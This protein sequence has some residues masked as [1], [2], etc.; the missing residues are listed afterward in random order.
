MRVKQT[1]KRLFEPPNQNRKAA[2]CYK[3]LLQAQPATKSNNVYCGS[4]D[5]LTRHVSFTQTKY[6]TEFCHMF[7]H[8][9]ML[10]SV[11]DKAKCPVDGTTV[12]N[13]LVYGRKFF[14]KLR[15]KQKL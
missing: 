15:T 2:S 6:L 4:A 11:D 12:V 9:C 1:L 14:A 8:E 10:T 7:P 13:W 3:S 5:E